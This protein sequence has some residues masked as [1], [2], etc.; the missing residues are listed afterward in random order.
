MRM[1]PAGLFFIGA[2]L[3]ASVVFAKPPAA[4]EVA[5]AERAFAAD[6]LRLGFSASFQRWAAPDGVVLRPDPVNARAWYAAHPGKPGD[7]P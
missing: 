5:A 2:L 4:E 6:A 1:L 7:P 3:S